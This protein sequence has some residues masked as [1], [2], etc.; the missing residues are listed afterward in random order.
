MLNELRDFELSLV[1]TTLKSLDNG[2]ASP[3]AACANC[4]KNRPRGPFK[5]CLK[6]DGEFDGAWCNSRY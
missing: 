5:S 2:K 4:T 1:T 3:E 6:M